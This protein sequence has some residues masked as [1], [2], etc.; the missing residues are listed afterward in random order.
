M[1]WT[2]ENPAPRVTTEVRYELS[3]ELEIDGVVRTLSR[4]RDEFHEDYG[5]VSDFLET[6]GANLERH[7]N[8]RW[9]PAATKLGSLI[10]YAAFRSSGTLPYIT[11]SCYEAALEYMQKVSPL[12]ALEGSVL[13]DTELTHLVTNA[14]ELVE[15][16]DEGGTKQIMNLAAGGV[17]LFIGHALADAA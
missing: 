5:R 13:Y 4:R 2:P 8:A 10:G 9:I 6:F 14:A 15:P 12:A 7:Y 1:L 17:R 16:L 11:G 3:A